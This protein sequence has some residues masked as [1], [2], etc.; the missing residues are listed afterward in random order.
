MAVYNRERYLAATLDSIL[1]QSFS[2]FELI[3]ADDGSTDS[4]LEIAN[5]Y[6]ARDSRIRIVALPHGGEIV[7]RNAAIANASPFSKYLMNHDSDDLSKPDKLERLVTYLQDHPEIAIVG[8]FADYID[9]EGRVIGAPPIESEPQ[10][11]RR[12]FGQV[13]SVIHSAALIRREVIQQIGGYRAAYR[14]AEDYDFFARTLLAGYEVANI[15]Q[16]LH[17]VRLHSATI[18][19]TRAVGIRLQVARIQA[20]YRY[21]Q[22]S[23]SAGILRRYWLQGIRQFRKARAMIRYLWT[24]AAH[25]IAHRYENPPHG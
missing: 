16:T 19:N 12:T 17:S 3:I 20:D 25:G 11:I 4:S 23:K 5:S 18:S 14:N 15:P 10:Q 7:T 21:A 2:D 13:N 24:N 6:A 1:T 9:D 22:Q 8:C